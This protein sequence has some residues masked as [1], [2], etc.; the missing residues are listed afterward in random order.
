MFFLVSILLVVFCSVVRFFLESLD[1]CD[2]VVEGLGG[3][4]EFEVAVGET[5]GV[6]HAVDR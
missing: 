3:N 5:P 6:G 4:A 1:G 2:V